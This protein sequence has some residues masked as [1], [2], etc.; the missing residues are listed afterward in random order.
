MKP[1]IIIFLCVSLAV[2]G[3]PLT[4]TQKNALHICGSAAVTSGTA[5]ALDY[6]TDAEMRECI[7]TGI[8]AG[9]MVGVG[10]EIVDYRRGHAFSA[11][12][13]GYDCLGVAIGAIGYVIIK[14]LISPLL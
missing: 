4:N 11:S 10:K 3:N 13:I 6:G 9:A 12:D 8:V 2:A 5:M 14:R 1:L 7:L